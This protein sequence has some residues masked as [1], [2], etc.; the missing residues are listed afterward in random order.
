MADIEYD[1]IDLVGYHEPDS[2]LEVGPD[3]QK[4]A[5]PLPGQY[6]VGVVVGGKF[7]PL[8]GF[9]AGNLVDSENTVS[10][11]TLASDVSEDK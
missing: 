9:K 1:K 10:V 3:G 8:A 5:V 4:H 6:H 7:L 2:S 11:N